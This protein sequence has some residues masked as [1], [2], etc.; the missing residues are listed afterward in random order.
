MKASL[1]PLAILALAGNAHA[2]NVI[3]TNSSSVATNAAKEEKPQKQD[4]SQ[5]PTSIENVALTVG[6]GLQGSSSGEQSSLRH[7]FPF[8]VDYVFNDKLTLGLRGSANLLRRKTDNGSEE[9]GTE[10]LS[11]G[12]NLSLRNDTGRVDLYSQ[13]HFADPTLFELEGKRQRSMALGADV[14]ARLNDRL[15]VLVGAST[16]IASDKHQTTF[17][18]GLSREYVSGNFYAGIGNEDDGFYG[19]NLTYANLGAA[20]RVDGIVVSVEA[21]AGQR[22]GG[23]VSVRVPLADHVELKVSGEGSADRD[24]RDVNRLYLA[25]ALMFR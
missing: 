11:I 19:N 6:Y 2:D 25:A 22:S 7:E 23:S 18:A 16:K 5:K 13:V 24:E 21:M 9:S 12:P 4:T 8:S 20:T 3:V 14:K 15:A 10:A 17:N 1:I